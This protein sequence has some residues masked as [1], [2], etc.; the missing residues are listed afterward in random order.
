MSIK[1]FK[2]FLELK[3]L[4]AFSSGLGLN[5]FESCFTPFFLQTLYKD[6]F[7]ACYNIFYSSQYVFAISVFDQKM[8][9]SLKYPKFESVIHIKNADGQSRLGTVE[10]IVTGNE[11]I[12]EKYL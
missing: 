5:S 9:Y 4:G 12:R 1:S 2:S 8:D 3:V 11:H 6:M 7:I 10:N